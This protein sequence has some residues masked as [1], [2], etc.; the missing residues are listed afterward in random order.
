MSKQNSIEQKQARRRE[1][2]HA[3]AQTET[4][5][6]IPIPFRIARQL[7]ARP[8]DRVAR[9]ARRAARRFRRASRLLETMHPDSKFRPAVELDRRVQGVIQT[10]ALADLKYRADRSAKVVAT[11]EGGK[12]VKFSKAVTV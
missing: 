9:Q 6:R 3:T 8:I 2:Q 10:L 11:R 7:S 4:E 1:R 12:S 5:A